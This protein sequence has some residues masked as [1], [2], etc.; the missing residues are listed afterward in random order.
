VQLERD[1]VLAAEEDDALGAGEEEED[2]ETLFAAWR[3][4]REREFTQAA[5]DL[6]T[7][8]RREQAAELVLLQSQL[9][10]IKRIRVAQSDGMEP[11]EALRASLSDGLGADAVGFIETWAADPTDPV[12]VRAFRRPLLRLPKIRDFLSQPSRSAIAQGYLRLLRDSHTSA[13]KRERQVGIFG[14]IYGSRWPSAPSAVACP[15]DHILPQKWYDRGTKLLT[16]AGDPGQLPHS[17]AI[18]LLSENSAKGDLPLGHLQMDRE[19]KSQGLY[20]TKVSPPKQARMAKI[21][22]SMFALYPLITDRKSTAGIGSFSEGGTGVSWYAR[23]WRF[24]KMRELA[25]R[26]ATAFE[27]RINLITAAVPRW[28]ACDPFTFDVGAL[29]ED[30]QEVV[31]RRLKG[32]D[33]LSK[34]VD[35]ALRASVQTPPV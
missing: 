29:D 30:V 12:W 21:T 35:A 6:W 19:Q 2:E 1:R 18:S 27:R 28:A 20:Y 4:E 9:A 14:S 7:A 15:P 3:A 32:V 13:S 17:V 10:A 25:L 31:E 5:V 23:A 33:G 24:G 11:A 16:E 26:P 8:T 22:T 34:L